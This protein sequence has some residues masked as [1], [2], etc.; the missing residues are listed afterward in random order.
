MAATAGR[1]GGWRRSWPPTSSAIRGSSSRTRPARWPRSRSCAREVIDPLLAEH[2]GRIVKLMGDG[3]IVEFGS[4]VDAVACAVALQKGVAAAAGRGPARAAHRLP[5]R[6][7]SRRRGGRGRRPAR[8]RGQRRGP[9]GAALRAGRRAGLRH[10]LRPPAG[11]AR[12]A[13]RLRRRAAGQEHRRPVRAYRVR[14]DGRR[15]VAWRLRLRQHRRRHAAGGRRCS[16]RSSSSAAAS[17]GC[18]RSTPASAKP[19]DRRAAVRQSRRRRGDRAARRRDHRGHHHRPRPLP[20]PRRDRP[21]LDRG[22]QGQAGRRAP[23]RHAT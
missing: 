17:G 3:A 21:Q 7:Q 2:H 13:A 10:R 16:W 14:L 18:G 5:D 22:L 19:S 12:P 15:P 9:A 11:Q 23:G 4:V 8:R 20:R 1:S 6:H